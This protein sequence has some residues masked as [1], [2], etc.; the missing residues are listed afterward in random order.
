MY[1]NLCKIWL[2]FRTCMVTDRYGRIFTGGDFCSDIIISN[3]FLAAGFV[4]SC[5]LEGRLMGG[6]CFKGASI[7]HPSCWITRGSYLQSTC[8]EFYMPDQ[9]I[10][11]YGKWNELRQKR[12]LIAHRFKLMLNSMSNP[13]LSWTL[14]MIKN[15][16]FFLL[17]DLTV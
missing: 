13:I 5:F 7:T 16:K 4:T 10:N 1:A 6:L 12:M 15:L 17:Q 3:C 2:C 11:C 8:S 9:Q 14:D